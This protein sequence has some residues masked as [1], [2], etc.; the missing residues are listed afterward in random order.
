VTAKDAQITGEVSNATNDNGQALTST[1]LQP[2]E[3]WP[4]NVPAVSTAQKAAE[5]A[6]SIPFELDTGLK[7]GANERGA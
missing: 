3:E 1:G 4:E 6:E 7:P 5:A 2:G